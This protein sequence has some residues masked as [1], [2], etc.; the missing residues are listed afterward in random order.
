MLS[1]IN[2]KE[3]F[4]I[5]DKGGNILEYFARIDPHCKSFETSVKNSLGKGAHGQVYSFPE[6][7]FIKNKTVAVKQMR[8]EME[9]IKSSEFKWKMFYNEKEFEEFIYVPKNLLMPCNRVFSVEEFENEDNFYFSKDGKVGLDGTDVFCLS[10]FLISLWV[11][12]FYTTGK[13]IN[14][15]ETFYFAICATPYKKLAEYYIF[16]EQIDDNLHS[17]LKSDFPEKFYNNIYI[18]ILF[19]VAMYQ[20]NGKIVHGDLHSGNIF[21]LKQ[22]SASFNGKSILPEEDYMEYRYKGKSFY[23]PTFK[24]S[25]D[26]SQF[27]VKIGDWD[28]AVK[29][30]K[31]MIGSRETMAKQYP[32]SNWYNE[33]LDILTITRSIQE[34]KCSSLLIR[35]IAAWMEGTDIN[36]NSIMNSMRSTCYMNN[37][38]TV[39]IDYRKLL[40]TKYNHVTPDAIL[41]NEDFM[42][43]YLQPPPKGS[44][45]IVCGVI[46]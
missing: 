30:S 4:E 39:Q 37:L 25:P 12:N 41:M 18:Q 34:E 36:C 19:A 20:H 38:H 43:D 11:G 24:T 9:K 32:I 3:V 13:C 8:V 26:E 6:N 45:I 7:V 35:K 22:S 21:L 44:K 23:I 15:I 14:F 17:Y 31:P 40:E 28:R 2:Q 16:M 27:V 10:E 1:P 46:D 5:I 33:S 42:K 29:Y